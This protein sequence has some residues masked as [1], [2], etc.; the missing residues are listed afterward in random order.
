MRQGHKYN[1]IRDCHEEKGYPI[2][3]LC[4][5]GQ[6]SHAAYYRW[7]TG[8]IS[9]RE[10]ENEKLAEII[11]R[12]HAR[13]P[14]MG[15]RRIHDTLLHDYHIHVNDK[16]VL[17]ICQIMDIKSTI[18]YCSHSCTRHASNPLYIA[19]NI[20]NRQFHAAAP[21]EKWLTDVTEFRWQEGSE[22][23][24]IYLSAILDLYDRRIVAYKI[25]DRNDNS[26][27]FQTFDEAVAANPG[28]HPMFHS[29][30]GFQYTGR[31]FHARLEKAGMVQSMSRVGHC[32]DNGPMEGFW[33]ILKRESYYGR[34]FTS[35]EDL[36]KMIEKYITYYNNERVQRNLGRITPMEKHELLA[37]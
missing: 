6:V 10:A 12:I 29:D 28:A 7:A 19:E 26:L 33:G 35:R 25:S 15:F 11:E 9:R 18:K 1:A 22:T 27:V 20:L 30:R 23:H 32:I 8:K 36:V 4:R 17:R 31:A 5:I 2:D 13:H 14:D 34:H 16:R 24:K 37:A 3:L 21:D